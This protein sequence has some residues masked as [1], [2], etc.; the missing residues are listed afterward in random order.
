MGK[1]LETKKKILKML[2]ERD[3]T[4]SELSRSLNLSTATVSQHIGELQRMG[5]V[6]KVDNEHFKRLK[7]YRPREEVNMNVVKYV[8]CAVALLA[9][10][11]VLYIYA[12]RMGSPGVAPGVAASKIYNSSSNA[13]AVTIGIP[14]PAGLVDACPMISYELNGSITGY[15]GFSL[16]YL[17]SSYGTVADFVIPE[18]SSGS[19]N[20]SEF[21]TSV[22]NPNMT[23]SRQHYVVLTNAG[24]EYNASVQGITLNITPENYS[25]KEN[26]ELNLTVSI[27]TNGTASGTYWLR[28][29]GPC[30]GGVTAA[31]ITVGD[32]A[33]TGNLTQKAVPYA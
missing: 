13:S 28:I 8:L 12:A 16:Y 24:Q 29:D 20:A 7:Y 31:L 2:R 3:Q 22:L 23:M 5:A 18:D 32:K 14:Q 26:E 30:G 10:V 21:V 33:Y 27:A 4:I 17:N 11:S 9:I 1:T 6:E 15:S 19:I 25:I